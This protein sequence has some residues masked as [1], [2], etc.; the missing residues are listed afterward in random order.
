MLRFDFFLFTQFAMTFET[1]LKLAREHGMRVWYNGA[2]EV[3]DIWKVAADSDGKPGSPFDH[4]R[5]FY[6]INS[7]SFAEFI[8]DT[9]IAMGWFRT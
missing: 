2:Q 1:L 5:S 6:Q 3:L 9:A 7:E 4:V 8:R